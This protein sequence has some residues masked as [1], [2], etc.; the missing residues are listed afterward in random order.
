MIRFILY[1]AVL[2]TAMR[3]QTVKLLANER[4]ASDDLETAKRAEAQR[5]LRMLNDTVSKDYNRHTLRT[6]ARD[7]VIDPDELERWWRAYHEGGL[8]GLRPDW[9]ELGKFAREIAAERY[10]FLGV[11]ADQEY[12]DSDDIRALA[13]I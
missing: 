6:R 10:S 11:Y 8:D 4:D 3:L 1:I 5:R 13:E 7:V 9:A 12:L 2:I